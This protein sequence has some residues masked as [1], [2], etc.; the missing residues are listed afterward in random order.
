[1]LY[2]SL[3]LAALL[4]GKID[5]KSTPILA[6]VSIANQGPFTFLVDT[7]ADTSLIDPTLAAKLRIEP[8][9]RI[10]LI[11]QHGTTLVPAAQAP[12]FQ[13]NGTKL[14]PL[15][16]LFQ[17]MAEARRLDPKVQGILGLNALKAFDFRLAP[18]SGR[19]LPL[20][21][22]APPSG[23]TLPFQPIEGRL[24]I[25][26]RMGAETLHL[27]LDSG[28]THIVLFKTP[29][30]MAKVRPI[31]AQFAT[32]DGARRQVPTSWTAEL[33]LT[34]TLRFKTLPAAIVSRPSTK[35]DGLLPVALFKEITVTHANSTLILR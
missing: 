24:V 22:A 35:I 5:T 3:L 13:V 6:D 33:T 34:P 31:I 19:L 18:P 12:G 28:A 32:I 14:P 20:D 1:M 2:C 17:D 21:P 7:G 4:F 25:E 11:T 29:A 8:T 16:V 10:E 27:A 26:A 23:E 15:E 30:A 9:Y